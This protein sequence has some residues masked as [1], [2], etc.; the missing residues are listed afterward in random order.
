M[1]AIVKQLS[2]ADLGLT[3][4]VTTSQT[5]SAFLTERMPLYKL[6]LV[7]GTVTGTNPTLTPQLIGIDRDGNSLGVAHAPMTA[8]T[9]S[10]TYWFVFDHIDASDSLVADVQ[11]QLKLLT[12][13]TS[14]SFAIT[15]A[16]LYGIRS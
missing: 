15:S 8:I 14:P 1:G 9:A 2:L 10:G 11:L 7:I 4:P 13:G 12:G 16:T 6:K 5:G 3:S